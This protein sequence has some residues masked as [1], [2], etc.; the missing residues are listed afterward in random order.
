MSVVDLEVRPGIDAGAM[1]MLDLAA[2]HAAPLN[3]DPFEYLTAIRPR[4]QM[5]KRAVRAVDQ[6]G[7]FV[8]REIAHVGETKV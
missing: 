1:S 6:R 2:F 4:R 5:E 7:A 3:R 8:E